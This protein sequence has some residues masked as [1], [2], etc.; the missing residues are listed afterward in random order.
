[1]K[2]SPSA[3]RRPL[4]RGQI[5]SVTAVLLLG[6]VAGGYLAVVWA[7]VYLLH[8]EVRQTVRGFINKAVHDRNDERLVHDLCQRLQAL[9]QREGEDARGRPAQVPVVDVEPR[10]VTWERDLE[11]RPPTLHVAFEYVRVV[12]YPILDRTTEKTMQ[13][14]LT[15]EIDVPV[16]K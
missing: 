9:E 6:L 3:S 15:G 14:D 11:A 4:E 13:V 1:M 2:R 16:W 7:P 8:H 5:T 12:R 10:D